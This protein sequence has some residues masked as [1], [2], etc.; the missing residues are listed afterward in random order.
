[1]SLKILVLGATGMLGSQLFIV[2]KSRKNFITYGSVR[3]E[4]SKNVFPAEYSQ[5]LLSGVNAED[6]DTIRS[7]IAVVKPAVIINCIGL[8]KQN[9]AA[10][11]PLQAI[12][13][14]AL[15]PQLLAACCK[16]NGC[17]VL[18]IS[19]DCVFDGS[20][21][22]YQ[23]TDPPNPPDLYGRTKLLG[24]L[25]QSHCLTIR[26]SIIGHEIQNAHGLIQWFL[27]Q[28]QPIKGYT[29]AVFS[30]FPTTELS[31]IIADEIIPRP[32][33]TG[34]YH[35]AS[36]PISKY[37]L[38]CLV[39][40]IYQKSLPIEADEALKLDRSLNASRFRQATGYTPPPWPQLIR[41]MFDDYCSGP[42][43]QNYS[44]GGTHLE[45]D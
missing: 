11:D 40:T 16:D 26:T 12:T 43:F 34:L 35:V 41:Q 8:V 6:F 19:T 38:L 1:M 9:A 23:E 3:R 13:I 30:G 17:R 42:L 24:E 36:E 29:Q 44:K 10:K 5:S 7:A 14:N 2:L 39:K 31:R 21:G 27:S 33:L 28:T 37:D 22:N 15:L 4:A 45:G 20:K 32:E 25:Y 18:Q